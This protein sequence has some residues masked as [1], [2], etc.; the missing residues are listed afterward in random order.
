M[1]SFINLFNS[2][3]AE[4]WDCKGLSQ[5]RVKELKYSELAREMAVLQ[6][7][8]QEAGLGGETRFPSMPKVVS[9]G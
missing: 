5:F 1:N 3:V 7:M 2:S 8:W 6:D 4:C 9:I